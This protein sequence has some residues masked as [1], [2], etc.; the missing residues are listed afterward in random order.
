MIPDTS[1]ILHAIAANFAD[2]HIDALEALRQALE[3]DTTGDLYLPFQTGL[4]SRNPR[5][6]ELERAAWNA[7]RREGRDY[8]TGFSVCVLHRSE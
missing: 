8:S 6:R 4:D 5:Q 3:V 1:H 7:E 2:G